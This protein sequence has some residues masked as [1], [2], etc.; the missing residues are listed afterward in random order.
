MKKTDGKPTMENQNTDESI[1]DLV[2]LSHMRLD[3]LG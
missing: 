2:E 1:D 3:D